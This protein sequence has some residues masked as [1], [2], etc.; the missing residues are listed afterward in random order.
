MIGQ[1]INRVVLGCTGASLLCGPALSQS[2]ASADSFDEL[3]MI[4]VT[5]QKREE[6][7]L[8]VPMSINAFT[9]DEL[10]NRG[11]IDTRDLE[12]AVPGLT[13]TESDF[14]PP[15][16]TLR[17]VGYY[18]STL[19]AAPAV[20]VYVDEVPLPYSSMTQNA[21]LDLERVE[22]LKGPQGTLF[23]QN[24]TG[25]AINYVAAKPTSD[26]ASGVDASAGNYSTT[27]VQ[28]FVKWPARWTAS[29]ARLSVRY[30]LNQPPGSKATLDSIGWVT[31]IDS[32]RDYLLD[33]H[34]NDRFDFL[35]NL[36]TSR[37]RSDSQ[38]AQ[39]IWTGAATTRVS[40]HQLLRPMQ[41][42]PRGDQ[43]ADWTPGV[44]YRL[45]NRFY[46]ASVRSS[47]PR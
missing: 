9:A 14:G 47:A 46:Q 8:S 26:F 34:P 23:G 30:P 19:A 44:D 1:S 16:Y 13:Y 32:R 22:V 28:A 7:S 39:L 24:S 12:R 10:L 4:V 18:D 33:V 15:T 2:S 11:I 17:G 29:A 37:D 45:D 35:V 6:S 20:S 43:S 5:A 27:D 31:P 41:T 21:S 36:N 42:H 40:C 3:P 38:A 25:G